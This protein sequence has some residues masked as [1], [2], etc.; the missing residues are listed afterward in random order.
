MLSDF[1]LVSRVDCTVANVQ[2]ANVPDQ[3]VETEGSRHGLSICLAEHV[4]E[5]RI[6]RWTVVRRPADV[7]HPH[8][9]G[10]VDQNIA[11][12]LKPVF[13][14]L[15]QAISAEHKLKVSPDRNRAGKVPPMGSLHAIGAIHLQI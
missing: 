13:P 9:A 14:G 3:S 7:V 4:L 5:N 6:G 1:A 15:R 2:V 10:G 8:S 12:Q 11:T